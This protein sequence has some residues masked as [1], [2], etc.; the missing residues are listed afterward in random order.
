MDCPV[1]HEDIIQ[2]GYA[3]SIPC[4]HV[5]HGVCIYRWV[6]AQKNC[7]VCRASF[8]SDKIAPLFLTNK[9]AE[10]EEYKYTVNKKDDQE[11]GTVFSISVEINHERERSATSTTTEETIVGSKRIAWSIG[12]FLV[13]LVGIFVFILI[14]TLREYN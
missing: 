3:A 14:L 12:T 7:P 1:C 6:E 8:E 13:C 11:N 2:T 5:F 10:D 9:A 4:G